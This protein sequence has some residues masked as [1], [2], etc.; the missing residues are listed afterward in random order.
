VTPKTQKR[1]W[2]AVLLAVY[3]GLGHVYLREWLRAMLW[4]GLIITSAVLLVPPASLPETMSV[5]AMATASRQ[6]PDGVLVVVLGITV[7]SMVD[8]YW[9]ATRT[10][11]PS[12]E[13]GRRCPSC[14]KETDEDLDFCHWCT[15]RLPDDA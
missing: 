15:E 9:I 7:L 6:L 10:E 8:A 4:F 3:P 2:L 5:T 13:A 11:Q 14:G 1:R 12:E